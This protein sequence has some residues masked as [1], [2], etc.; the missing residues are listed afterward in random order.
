MSEFNA[1]NDEILERLLAECQ[2]FQDREIIDT[3][4]TRNDIERNNCALN[5]Y[6][7]IGVEKADQS[8]AAAS[9]SRAGRASSAASNS[10][11]PAQW[12]VRRASTTREQM[13]L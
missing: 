1:R 10:P 7:E 9:C 4:I 6:N 3:A 8:H 13:Q 5:L 11:S 2:I 12:A